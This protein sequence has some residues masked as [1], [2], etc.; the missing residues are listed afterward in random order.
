MSLLRYAAFRN[1][2]AVCY[3]LLISVLA[4]TPIIPSGS[5]DLE[6]GDGGFLSGDPCGPPCF[7]GIVPGVTTEAETM[8]IFK[9]RGLFEKCETYN[10]E[11]ESGSRGL[12]CASSVGIVFR[13]NTDIVEE[14]G[15]KPSSRIT[16]EDVIA[17]YGEPDFVLVTRTSIPEYP[18]T[19]MI[20]Y[21]DDMK[22]RLVLPDQKGSSFQI[23]AS[24]K[25][26]NIGYADKASY[27]DSISRIRK[28]LQ[29]WNGYTEYE[30]NP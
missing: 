30:R 11:A 14:V 28:F 20:F 12:S 16:V 29:N 17:E 19:G 4:C 1:S 18:R 23:E 25:I 5:K 8:Q 3:L 10:N 22:A 21:Y 13:R 15:F 6:V 9:A 7:W 2:G 24:I 26:E 27:N